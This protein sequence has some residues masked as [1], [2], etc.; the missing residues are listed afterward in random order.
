MKQSTQ[1]ITAYFANR[2]LTLAYS[3]QGIREARGRGKWKEREGAEGE[4]GRFWQLAIGFAVGIAF[5]TR[6]VDSSSAIV[7]THAHKHT[8]TH[9]HQCVCHGQCKLVTVSKMA[10]TFLIIL[11]GNLCQTRAQL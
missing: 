5:A 8:R 7:A 10:A 6:H 11:N 9:T 4:E 2:Y 1:F 3:M